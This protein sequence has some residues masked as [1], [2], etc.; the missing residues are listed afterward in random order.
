MASH[1]A[2]YERRPELRDYNAL[3][4]FKRMRAAAGQTEPLDLSASQALH[5]AIVEFDPDIHGTERP[6]G[7]RTE[8]M[9]GVDGDAERGPAPSSEGGPVDIPERSL[10]ESLPEIVNHKVA[11][12]EAL[13]AEC[14]AR[15]Q[16]IEALETRLT[17]LEALLNAPSGR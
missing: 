17:R 10:P 4:R 15:Q 9:L 1:R 13:R 11:K 5:D 6:H 7:L 2:L 12:I 8:H 16:R 14:A 3:E